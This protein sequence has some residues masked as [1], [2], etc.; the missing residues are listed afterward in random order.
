M[1]TSTGKRVFLPATFFESTSHALFALEKRTEP[2]DLNYPYIAQDT[3]EIKLPAAFDIESLPKD[4][5]FSDPQNTLYRAKFTH[6]P[7]ALKSQRI[8][9]VGNVV[10]KADEY[11]QL[12]DFYQKVN[13]KDKEPAVLQFTQAAST[14]SG[15]Q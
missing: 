10:Y 13:A 12:K 5:E 8:L 7:G 15:S 2:I 11:P 4:S 14:A 1:G 6:E 9:V 3:V